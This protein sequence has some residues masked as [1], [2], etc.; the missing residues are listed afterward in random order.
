[1]KVDHGW[2]YYS[3][4]DQSVIK[5]ALCERCVGEVVSTFKVPPE[6]STYEGP[7]YECRCCGR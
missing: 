3:K 5:F 6:T 4:Q 1:V 7:F 2:G